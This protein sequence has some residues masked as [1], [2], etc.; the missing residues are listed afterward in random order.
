MPATASGRMGF[1]ISVRFGNAQLAKGRVESTTGLERA[2]RPQWVE[3]VNSL[4]RAA[5][6]QSRAFGAVG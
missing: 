6:F 2:G 4:F 5:D 3:S 1:N